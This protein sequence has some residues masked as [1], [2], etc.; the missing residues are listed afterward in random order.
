MK[1]KFIR[2]II[3]LI[4]V[5]T[6]AFSST[7][8]AAE[9]KLLPL[10]SLYKWSTPQDI[11]W[12]Y[13]QDGV[14]DYHSSIV[15][16]LNGWEEKTSKLNY[17]EGDDSSWDMR[18]WSDDMGSTGWHGWCNPVLKLVNLNDYYYSSFIN[19]KAELVAHEVGHANGLD[20]V[21]STKVLMRSSG[22]NHSKY[23]TSDDIEGINQLY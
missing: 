8:L 6:L 1:S 3:I 13:I 15:S 21:D 23:P 22:Y 20:D 5:F 10:A 9:Y 7:V 19:D 2:K 11:K 14:Y 17:S 4:G 16:G 18:F 12:I